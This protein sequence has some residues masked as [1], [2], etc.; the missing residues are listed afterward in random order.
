MLLNS[1][2]QCIRKKFTSVM[3]TFRMLWR[4]VGVLNQLHQMHYQ[5]IAFNSVLKSFTGSTR[6]ITA[7]SSQQL[8]QKG[9]EFI[10]WQHVHHYWII[11]VTLYEEASQMLLPMFCT[12]VTMQTSSGWPLK[13]MHHFKKK[14]LETVKHG[15]EHLEINWDYFIQLKCL[16]KQE[17]MCWTSAIKWIKQ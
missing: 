7:Q 16:E 6:S 10:L 13:L 15:Q 17:Y 4:N 1:P 9:N 11:D 8:P 14:P 12:V 2:I 5:L 3:T